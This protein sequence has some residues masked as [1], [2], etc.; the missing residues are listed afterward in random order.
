MTNYGYPDNSGQTEGMHGSADIAYPGYGPKQHTVTTEGAGTYDDPITA[1]GE[2]SSSYGGATL[3]PGTIIY[4]PVTQK[5]YI[6]ED[7]CAECSADYNCKYDKDQAKGTAGDPPASGMCDT[8][9]F[10]HIDFYMGPSDDLGMTLDNTW[11]T[12]E[13]NT[14][15]GDVYMLNGAITGP[16]N[17]PTT[18]GTV[19]VNPPNNLP[20]R[21]GTLFASDGTCW[22]ST[23]VLP[24]QMYCH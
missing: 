16:P 8:N 9:Q 24:T 21:S 5:Y 13:S 19:I 3:D 6:M 22:T 23:Q 12:C 18:N 2:T 15:I 10:L 1:A 17:S 20:V 4:N 14:T 11:Q 7:S